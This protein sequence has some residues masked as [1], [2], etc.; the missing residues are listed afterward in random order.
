MIR[1]IGAW[2]KKIIK[3]GIIAWLIFDVVA[4]GVRIILFNN[5]YNNE[6]KMAYLYKNYNCGLPQTNLNLIEK[7][8][9]KLKI[10]KIPFCIYTQSKLILL[11]IL[12]L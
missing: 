5:F 10:M 7:K 6:Q 3:W 11:I 8:A 4:G 9:D 12:I 1:K 2:I